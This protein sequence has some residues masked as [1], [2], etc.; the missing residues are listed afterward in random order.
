[1]FNSTKPQTKA[2]TVAFC[3]DFSEALQVTL[4]TLLFNSWNFECSID[5]LHLM[6]NENPEEAQEK[7]DHLKIEIENSLDE[8]QVVSTHLFQKKGEQELINFINTQNYVALFIGLS[9]FQENS[10]FGEFTRSLY[11]QV[12]CDIA[13]VPK[14]HPVK[15]E[16]KG[17][18]A[19]EFRNLENLYCIQ[20]YNAYF[21][22]L[23]TSLNFIVISDKFLQ[24][25]EISEC[26]SEIQNILPDLRYEITNFRKV[27]SKELL[28]K[29]LD[30]A[31]TLDYFIFFNDDYLESLI[32]N[33]L[34]TNDISPDV[35]FTFMKSYACKSLIKGIKLGYFDSQKVKLKELE[36]KLSI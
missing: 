3:T 19:L 1:M 22:F 9:G 34:T 12:E 33:R 32:H 35:T 29:T 8:G 16:N 18:I 23:C 13:M 11:D 15:I 14:N 17:M 28:L 6:E 25:E 36:L 10:N 27:D 24:D 21:K 5:L 2:V 26:Y 31:N 30:S 7:L 20:K 4:N